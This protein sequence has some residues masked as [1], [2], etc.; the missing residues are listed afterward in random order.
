MKSEETIYETEKTVLDKPA[1]EPAKVSQSSAGESN[2][3][4]TGGNP[5]ILK[6]GAIAMGT[7]VF[8]GA[9]G[10][11][12][13]SAIA[14]AASGDVTPDIDLEPDSH[15]RPEWAS[16]D[17]NVATS[18]SDDMSFSEAFAAARA[19]VGPGGAF[20]WHGGIYG[21]YTAAEWANMTQE[22]KE[23]YFDHFDWS[24]REPTSS[25]S[26]GNS[27]GQEESADGESDHTGDEDANSGDETDEHDSP[28]AEDSEEPV[29]VIS[30][31]PEKEPESDEHS[32]N[33]DDPVV[34]DE[35]SDVEILGIMRDEETGGHIAGVVV[36]GQEAVLIDVDGDNV[37]DVMAADLNGDG[38][39]SSDEILDISEDNLTTDQLDP[40]FND[41]MFASNDG[42]TDYINEDMF[43]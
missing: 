33:D 23:D 7:G 32:T 13:F 12:A 28:N 16:A 11:M 38:E 25:S 39:I 21:T 18:V 1:A 40:A 20:E 37:F 10:S 9:V 42:E 2:G 22:E 19:E 43:V 35:T 14:N 3:A 36:D 26:G 30:V 29:E 6:R 5:S 27:S 15:E 4:T 24:Q 17:V 41:D 8:L 31:A 34:G